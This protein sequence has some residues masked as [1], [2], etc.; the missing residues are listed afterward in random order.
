MHAGAVKQEN[1]D[2]DSDVPIAQKRKAKPVAKPAARP[3][4]KQAAKPAAKRQKVGLCHG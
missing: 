4:A 2:D 3:A 1:S